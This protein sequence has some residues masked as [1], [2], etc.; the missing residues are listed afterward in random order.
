MSSVLIAPPGEPP[1]APRP[2]DPSPWGAIDGVEVLAEGVVFV[3]TPS[4]GGAWLSDDAQ[5]RMPAAIKPMHGRRWYEEDCEIWA[6]LLVFRVHNDEN[7]RS[8]AIETLARWQPDWLDA[9]AAQEGLPNS[10]QVRRIRDLHGELNGKGEPDFANWRRAARSGAIEG[11]IG[12]VW[13][14]ISQDGEAVG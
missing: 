1:G 11:W 6:P 7:S 13:F 2:R 8:R 9:L 10:A 5:T 12:G 3:S 14:T 4:H